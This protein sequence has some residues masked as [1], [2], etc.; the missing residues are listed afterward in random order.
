MGL[1]QMSRLM[2]LAQ[3]QNGFDDDSGQS[4]TTFSKISLPRRAEA[5]TSSHFQKLYYIDKI[6]STKFISKFIHEI[7]L[8]KNILVEQLDIPADLRV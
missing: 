1:A 8:F 5:N 6:L 4:S 7:S 3:I 2:G